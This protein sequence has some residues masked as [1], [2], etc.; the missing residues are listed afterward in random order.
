[1]RPGTTLHRLARLTCTGER[2]DRVLEPALADLQHEWLAAKSWSALLR[3][4]AVFWQSWG[5]CLLQDAIAPE[6]RSFAAI[7]LIAFAITVAGAALIEVMLMHSSIAVRR[8]IF[9]T[10][11]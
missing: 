2:C 9:Y 5:T 11:C 3:N 6:S 1:M 4:Y 7:T 10:S 8:L